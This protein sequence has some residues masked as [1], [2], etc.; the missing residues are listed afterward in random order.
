MGINLLPFGRE[1]RSSAAS[2]R[3]ASRRDD[4]A[5]RVPGAMR[6]AVFAS[7][8]P[9]ESR[10]LMSTTLAAVA[11]ATVESRGRTRITPIPTSAPTPPWWPGPPAMPRLTLT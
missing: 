9:L 7:V 3:R 10:R 8:E 1:N 2:D 6:S 4:A 5:R 11:D